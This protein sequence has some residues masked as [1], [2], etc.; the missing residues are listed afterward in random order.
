MSGSRSNPAERHLAEAEQHLG[1]RLAA[2]VDGEL[3]HDAR[4]RVL[5]HL[6]TCPMCKTEADAQRRLK[7]VFAQAAPPPPSESFLARLQG[8]PA[9]GT[10]P[11]EDPGRPGEGGG[12]ATGSTGSAG[13]PRTGLF[14]MPTEPFM[15]YAPSGA[16]AAVL[17]GTG[18][19]FRIHD[20]TRHDGDRS[21]WRGRRFAF[22]AAGAVSLA[23]IALG[24]VTAGVPTDTGDPRAGGAKANSNVTPQRAQGSGVAATPDS[25]RRRGAGNPLSAQGQRPGALS[26]PVAPTEATGPLLPGTAR[27]PRTHDAVYGLTAP[28]L[29][30]AATI[31][32]L[33]RPPQPD[34]RPL[35]APGLARPPAVGPVG[36]AADPLETTATTDSA[37][38]ATPPGSGPL[39]GA[40]RGY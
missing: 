13:L 16:H 19:G 7:S 36:T 25:L 27:P 23:A 14:G 33:I 35:A 8:L 39:L 1:D 5:A 6:A 2:L 30:G 10:E 9:G 31:S 29:A 28:M 17:P 20:V 22:A 21:L 37:T 4:E 34:H 11:P 26:A 32:P 40:S 24:G 15:R 18:R 12:F 3:G 38:A